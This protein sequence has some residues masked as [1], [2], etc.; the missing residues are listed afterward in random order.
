VTFAAAPRVRSPGSEW[1]RTRLPWGLADQVLSS[2]TNLALSIVAGRAL[3]PSGLGVVFIGF[4]AATIV[5][6]AQRALIAD[7]LV[8]RTSDESQ[9][10][11]DRATSSAVTSALALGGTTT[12]LFLSGGVFLPGPVG[13]GLLIVSPWMIPLC[14]QDLWR[15]VLF[16]DGRGRDATTNDGV[17][18][19]A[20]ALSAF[21]AAVAW[22]AWTVVGMWG[23]GALA[24]ALF[25]LRQTRVRPVGLRSSLAWWR[26]ACWPLGR[27]FAADRVALNLGTQG[28]VFLAAGLVGG[29]AL[30]GYRAAQSI[31]APITLLGP[32]I[33]LPGLPAIR[34]ASGRS[35]SRGFKLSILVSCAALS[36]TVAYLAVVTVIGLLSGDGAL[37]LVFGPGFARFDPLLAPIASAQLA[38]AVAIGSD[39][40]LRALG[41]GRALTVSHAIGSLALLISVL[42]Y[43]ADH[44]ITGVTW[45]V[46]VGAVVG[47]ICLLVAVAATRPAR[48]AGRKG[49]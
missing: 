21:V 14:V 8:V 41:R 42:A 31:F 46:T 12:L 19:V 20:M 23:T 43:G 10:V 26:T 5:L 40:F 48:S 28:V 44:G 33:A 45:G 35:W 25:G 2:G 18:A 36:V 1:F 27:W 24:G 47:T 49:G 4:T 17:W 22:S 13:T 6:L 11:R 15:V 32:A 34:Q 30:G 7:P 39:L 16:R 29:A 9:T 3:G 38:F 37:S